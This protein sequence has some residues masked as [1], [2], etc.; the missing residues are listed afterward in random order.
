MT[1]L[2]TLH[3][4]F[5]SDMNEASK[6]LRQAD[7]ELLG[8]LGPTHYKDLT[9][10]ILSRGLATTSARNPANTVNAV[11]SSDIKRYG[12][13]SKF[14]RVR[15]GVY[16][17][18]ARHAIGTV[19][20]NS[21]GSESPHILSDD[22][23]ADPNVFERRVRIPLFPTYSEVRH[24]LK[25]WNGR[26]QKQITHLQA[27]IRKLRG[28]P[29]NPVDWTQ[30]DAWIPKRLT[31]D[32]LDLAND[33]W[34][35]SNK[36][37]NPRHT[38][39]HWLLNRTYRLIVTDAGGILTMSDHGRDFIDREG[40]NTEAFLDEQE[41]LAKLLVM[42]ADNSPT[43]VS[44][45]LDEWAE[46]LD[47]YSR[48]GTPATRRETLRRRLN[49]LLDRGF[50]QRQQGAMYSITR[51]GSTYQKRLG[52]DEQQEIRT[53]IR[54]QKVSVRERLRKLLLNMDPFAFEHLVKVLLEKMGYQE[55]EVTSSAGDGGVDVVANLELGL[56]SV[57]E[58]VQAKRHRRTIQ[59]GVLDALRGSLPRFNAVRGTIIATSR[60]A[61][62]TKKASLEARVAPIT[63]I[64]GD[65]LIDLLIEHG[66]GVEKHTLHTVDPTVFADLERET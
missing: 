38:Y 41:G 1:D 46:Y 44:G 57:R 30:P 3:E 64:D 24:L 12:T 55:V 39:G 50:V 49:N 63:L 32:D 43:R 34:T 6:S 54:K 26:P 33:I 47:R 61:K 58:V 40:G 22:A 10:E 20:V 5:R 19:S 2:G 15:P 18:C 51:V 42:V 53:L 7:Q 16:R 48:F 21:R 25:V 8:E 4:T 60:F 28:T 13:G 31:G 17:L 65:R 62:G 27:T 56:S 29:R 45:L 66:I 59:R 9:H 36:N 35:R 14:I 37:V 23:D 11:L 52:G